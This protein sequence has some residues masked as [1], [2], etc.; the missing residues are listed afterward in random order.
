MLRN[1]AD[2]RRCL[3]FGLGLPVF[4]IA[5]ITLQLTHSDWSNLVT[6][7]ACAWYWLSCFLENDLFCATTSWDF[8]LSF[9]EFESA[10]FSW[11]RVCKRIVKISP[12]FYTWMKHIMSEQRKKLDFIEN[13]KRKVASNPRLWFIASHPR[14]SIIF[15]SFLVTALLVS[16]T[17]SIILAV[18]LG[19]E[20]SETKGRCGYH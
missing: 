14:L 17:L 12:L 11:S 16:L 3:Y 4:P 5:K 7:T 15:F 2:A 18:G 13:V 1:N 8:S 10:S 19:Q 6:H 20:L 9:R